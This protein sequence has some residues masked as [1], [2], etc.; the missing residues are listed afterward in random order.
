M[1]KIIESGAGGGGGINE[2]EVDAL[3]AERVD[4]IIAEK[5]EIIQE[6]IDKHNKEWSQM[7]DH[8]GLAQRASDDG[9]TA[10]KWSAWWFSLPSTTVRPAHEVKPNRDQ[11]N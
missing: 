7:R 8:Y 10:G 5:D 2:E 9:T 1:D 4:D 6:W 3:V 11:L